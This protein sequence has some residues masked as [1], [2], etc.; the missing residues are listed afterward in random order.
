LNKRT[1]HWSNNQ[2]CAWALRTAPDHPHEAIQQ[3][4]RRAGM[5]GIEGNVQTFPTESLPQLEE[6]GRSY[7][8]AGL[9]V[10]SFHL[11]FSG[12]PHVDIAAFYETYRVQAVDLARL[13]MQRAAALGAK[14]VIEHPTVSRASV[15]IEGEDKYLRAL[16]RSLAVLLPEAQSLGLT[17]A[18]ENMLPG[19]DGGRFGSRPKHFR[20]ILE[21]FDHPALGFCLDTGHALVSCHESAHEMF[22]AMAAKLAAFH[23]VDN[24]G[25]RDSHLAPGNGRVDWSRVF[26]GMARIEY[27]G[28]ACI[29]APPFSFGP[30]YRPEAF[31]EMIRD[32][33][34]LVERALG[35]PP[36][37]G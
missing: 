24:A 25:D 30:A 28:V 12:G 32:I 17:F 1:W 15:D 23:L 37:E 29:E 33:E 26:Q 20:R 11:P 5:R 8:D 34:R 22:E 7:R 19:D 18:L 16:D 9:E 21:A 14:V 6:I 2:L 13:W 35:S 31:I 3:V 36:D 4:C 27:R 10:Y